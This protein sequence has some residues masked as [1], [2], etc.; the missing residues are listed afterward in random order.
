MKNCLGISGSGWLLIV[1]LVTGCATSKINWA[2]RVGTYTHDQAIVELGPPDKQATL[3]DGTI[4]SE[5]LT[6]RGRGVAYVGG[7][8]YYG[9]PG[10]AGYYG[11]VYPAYVTP[12]PDYFLRLTFSPDGKLTAWKKLT[13]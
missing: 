6:Q 11:G 1:A 8:G 13:R 3:T 9:Y 7:A 2:A 10:R 4:V 12:G 5:W